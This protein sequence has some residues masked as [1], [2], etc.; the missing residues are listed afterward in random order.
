MYVYKAVLR[1]VAKDSTNLYIMHMDSCF[2]LVLSL[3][4]P[5]SKCKEKLKRSDK[6]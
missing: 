1:L 6:I 5:L 3:S 2:R 4:P